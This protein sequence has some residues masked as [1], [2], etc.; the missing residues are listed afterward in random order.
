M[1]QTLK[2]DN[3]GDLNI[4]EISQLNADVAAA[5][6]S[7]TVIN[8]ESYANTDYIYIGE[9]G[10]ELGETVVASG[11]TGATTI[12][13]AA[14]RLAHKRFDPIASLFGNKIRIYRAA[15]ADGTQPAD[16]DFV[17]LTTIDIDYDQKYTPYTDSGG[18]SDYWYKFTY[19]NSTSLAESALADSKSVRGGGVGNYVSVEAIRTEAGFTGNRFITDSR[20]DEA[21]QAAQ[22]TID[23]AL[24]DIYTVPFT[25]VPPNPI[26]A[27]IAKLLAAGDL[28]SQ[29]YGAFGGQAA[30]EGKKKTDEGM[31]LLE[32][33]NKRELILTDETGTSTESTNASGFNAWPNAT[34]ADADPEDGGAPRQFRMS[35]RY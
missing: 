29:S 4:L 7:L 22:R 35:D 26:I 32:K 2:I 10:G 19:Y 13:C 15:N 21:R 1:A 3:F 31:A 30:S 24:G 23:S 28:L 20:I 33:I 8:N 14:T 17:L 16:D 18:S 11:V 27:R 6:T 25:A 9:F 34:T 12:N 5:A